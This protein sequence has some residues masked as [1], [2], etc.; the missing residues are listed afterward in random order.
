MLACSLKTRP[1]KLGLVGCTCTPVLLS[2]GPAGVD[3]S[4]ALKNSKRKQIQNGSDCSPRL[5]IIGF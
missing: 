4:D 2:M 1:E 5:R 3:D